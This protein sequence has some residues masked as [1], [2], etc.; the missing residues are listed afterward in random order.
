MN[1]DDLDKKNFND[2]KK[3]DEG[4]KNRIKPN[5][6]DYNTDTAK[7]SWQKLA[8]YTMAIV[9]TVCIVTAL[10]T[11]LY[12]DRSDGGL[13]KGTDSTG[14]ST[15]NTEVNTNN[16]EANTKTAQEKVPFTEAQ[17]NMFYRFVGSNNKHPIEIEIL[18]NVDGYIIF[19]F[20]KGGDT[21]VVEMILGGFEIR[22]SCIY[23]PSAVG[24]YVMNDDAI[25]TLQQ[26][27]NKA[28]IS[29][30]TVYPLLPEN[31][32]I[33]KSEQP[34]KFFP[35]PDIMSYENIKANYYRTN[36]HGNWNGK[37]YP[38]TVKISSVKELDDYYNMYKD[39]YDFDYGYDEPKS[40]SDSVFSNKDEYNDLYFT[41]ND[42]LFVLVEHGSGTLRNKVNSLI[43]ESNH[44]YINI[45]YFNPY[46]KYAGGS[47]DMAEWHIVLEL[48][49]SLS[50]KDITVN[51]TESDYSD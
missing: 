33:G 30:E 34:D 21:A 14:V 48:D 44:L 49:K 10:F 39:I 28:K 6:L 8:T 16:T 40:M 32:K 25:Y 29:M 22:S 46:G 13:S 31:M 9:L 35:E 1:F 37:K 5:V 36:E 50:E 41:K 15:N 20:D 11:A 4:M 19:K 3:I 43:S 42:L 24:T 12:N 51:I 23:Y 2:I 18:G 45:E 38:D 27:Y 26:A 47:D 17:E 7:I